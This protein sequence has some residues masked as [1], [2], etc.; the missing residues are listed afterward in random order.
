MLAPIFSLRSTFTPY[1]SRC[2]QQLPSHVRGKEACWGWS[3]ELRNRIPLPSESSQCSL[4]W[5]SWNCELGV[6]GMQKLLT[7]CQLPRRWS[8]TRT[9]SFTVLCSILREEV[10]TAP[11][12]ISSPVHPLVL[13]PLFQTRR[14]VPG[15]WKHTENQRAF[16]EKVGN[17]LGIKKVTN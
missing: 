1:S 17:E 4:C 9:P 14:R 6:L 3:A 15:F 12:E 13:N 8:N 2:T 16:L 5:L 10:H 11:A 7:S